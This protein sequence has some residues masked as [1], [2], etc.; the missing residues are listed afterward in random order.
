M[1]QHWLTYSKQI[2]S[3]NKEFILRSPR[4]SSFS[5]P[6]NLSNLMDRQA[7]TTR[8]TVLVKSRKMT[9]RRQ[10]QPW[11]LGKGGVK[12][13]ENKIHWPRRRCSSH[14]QQL[15]GLCGGTVTLRCAQSASVPRMSYIN[16]Y[17]L[18]FRLKIFRH[19]ESNHGEIL[20]RFC[21]CS[22]I[23]VKVSLMFSRVLA[24][25]SSGC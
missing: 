19:S 13:T 21:S 9:G 2:L 6:R 11:W 1:C 20:Q 18:P 5:F 23:A 15:V 24:W 12:T 7:R 17:S 3:P 4:S 22:K 16:R 25:Y 10:T 14:F 8:G